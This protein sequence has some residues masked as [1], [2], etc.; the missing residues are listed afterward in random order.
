MYA[1]D[2]KKQEV[3]TEVNAANTRSR[4]LEAI[5]T[6]VVEVRRPYI[7]HEITMAKIDRTKL[8]NP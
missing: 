8:R 1:D 3:V 5:G 2:L 4:A 6:L 7:L